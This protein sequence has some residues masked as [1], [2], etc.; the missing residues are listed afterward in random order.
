[1]L[2]VD[3]YWLEA[4]DPT[5]AVSGKF[6]ACESARSFSCVG[7]TLGACSV[8]RIGAPG[9]NLFGWAQLAAFQ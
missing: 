9:G 5:A 6:V 2:G 8:E 4:V 7:S 3:V 1:M